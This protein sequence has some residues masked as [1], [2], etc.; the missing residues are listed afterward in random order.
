M[1]NLLNRLAA[2]QYQTGDSNAALE[3]LGQAIALAPQEAGLYLEKADLLL[4]KK[5]QTEAL[6]CLETALELKPDNPALHQKAARLHR[7]AGE[8]PIALAHAEKLAGTAELQVFLSQRHLLAGAFDLLPQLVHAGNCRFVLLRV[9]ALRD[10][11]ILCGL[12]RANGELA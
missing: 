9:P 8:L 2:A 5:C 4:E 3:T 1:L 10:G 7:A 6:A 12:L 11:A